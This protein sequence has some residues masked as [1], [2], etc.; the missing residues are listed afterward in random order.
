[1]WQRDFIRSHLERDVPTFA[2][3]IPAE[4]SDYARCSRTL[5]ARH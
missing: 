2:G 1:M 4:P 5:K 3:R